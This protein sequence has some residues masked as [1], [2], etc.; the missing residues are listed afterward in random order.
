MF[1]VG[2]KGNIGKK[3]V[4][5]FQIQRSIEIWIY[6]WFRAL[7]KPKTDKADQKYKEVPWSELVRRFR[8][9]GEP[10]K[11]FGETQDEACQRLRLV[12]MMA[13]EENKGCVK[14]FL[15]SRTLSYVIHC[16]FNIQWANSDKTFEVLDILLTFPRKISS[17]NE[18]GSS[19]KSKIWK[20]LKK[21]LCYYKP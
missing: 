9:K 21:L 14:K 13:K 11:L 1:A 18:V 5:F 19:H 6:I 15:L 10:I 17:K 7:I 12:E 3:R 4:K 16:A 2:S 20:T 8:E